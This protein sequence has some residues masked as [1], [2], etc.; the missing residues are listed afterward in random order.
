MMDTLYHYTDINGFFS[1]IKNKKLWV[2]AA[3][4]LNDSGELNWLDLKLAKQLNSITNKENESYLSEFWQYWKLTRPMHYICSFSKDG[5]VLSQWRAY[6]DDGYGV[7]IG[8]NRSYFDFY[9]HGPLLSF[10]KEHTT[11]LYDVIY[12]SETQDGLIKGI[13][14][15]L[16]KVNNDENDKTMLFVHLTEILKKF[17]YTF[18]NSAFHEENETRIIHTPAIFTN[19]KLGN[20]TINGSLSDIQCRV[21]NRNITTY[22]EYDF[23]LKKDV[24]PINKIILGP[25]CKL[26]DYDIDHLLSIVKMSEIELIKSTATYR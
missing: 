13:V 23:S 16:S 20:I 2:S 24:S 21:T 1:I 7:S 22:F 4:N 25:K 10:N 17:S 8:F 15:H 5:D 9:T 14:E 11:G 6:A 12:D 3:N 18:K 26:S 19:G